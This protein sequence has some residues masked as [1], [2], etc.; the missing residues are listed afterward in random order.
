ML[1]VIKLKDKSDQH[2]VH[3][4]GRLRIRD[5]ETRQWLIGTGFIE[6]KEPRIVSREYFDR[7]KDLGSW[8]SEQLTGEFYKIF[9]SLRDIYEENA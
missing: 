6:D 2:T 5:K 4:D 3:S 8:P 9:L 1:N 7:L